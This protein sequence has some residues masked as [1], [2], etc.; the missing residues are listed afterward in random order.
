MGRFSARLALW[1]AASRRGGGG[2]G[3]GA[4]AGA[5]DDFNRANSTTGLGTSSSGH[6]WTEHSGTGGI[7]ANRGYNEAGT[8]YASVDAGLAD[9]DFSVKVVAGAASA[10][11]DFPGIAYRVTGGS[12]FMVGCFD[13]TTAYIVKREAAS[14]STL[15]S[16]AHGGFADGDTIRVVVSGSAHSLQKGVVEVT[17][18]TSS[19][20]DTAE[21]VGLHVLG[22]SSRVDDF[23]AEP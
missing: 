15:A 4:P 12:D 14:N 2:G 20:Q 5:S 19:F 17:S 1:V 9:G 3:G 22:A 8:L 13:T 6:V 18:T 23:L 16:A 7:D 10:G 11:T 21:A